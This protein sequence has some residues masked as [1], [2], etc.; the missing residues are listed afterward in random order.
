VVTEYYIIYIIYLLLGTKLIERAV[1][2]IYKLQHKLLYKVQNT[3]YKVHNNLKDRKDLTLTLIMLLEWLF[4]FIMLLEWLFGWKQTVK[5][6]VW[7]SIETRCKF[8]LLDFAHFRNCPFCPD[9]NTQTL[10]LLH[11]SVAE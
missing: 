9:N 10:T 8:A 3:K 7:D 5:A 11:H 1:V 4:G 2:A 6:P